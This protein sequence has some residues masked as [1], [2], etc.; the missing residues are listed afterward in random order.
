MEP[1]ATATAEQPPEQPVTP[2]QHRAA[3]LPADAPQTV[4][5][6]ALGKELDPA[7]ES[8]AL[9]WFLGAT[10]R[11]EYD[12][13]VQWET[14]KGMKPLVFHLRQVDGD[15]LQEL[16]EE[17]RTG[18]GPFAKLDTMGF[19][20][21]VAAEACMYLTDDSGVRVA[22]NESRF[23]GGAPSPVIAMRGRFKTQPGILETLAERIRS[24]AGYSP[25]RVGGAQRALV[26]T[27]KPS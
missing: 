10:T 26:E 13:T 18:D 19:N 6:A 15:R 14:P 21:S 4:R 2:E 17:N 25:D 3:A 5:D 24:K 23:L 11:L 8:G 27:G 7:D 16:D 9:D 20:A 12:V 22:V 1:A